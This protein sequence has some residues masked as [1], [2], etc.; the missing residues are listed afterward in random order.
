MVPW[1]KRL[2]YSLV[3]WVV[4]SCV[5]GVLVSIWESAHFPSNRGVSS[6]SYFFDFCLLFLISALAIGSWGWLLGMPFVLLVRN[7]GGW[8]FWIY[9]AIGSSI[10][11]G[12]FFGTLLYS[13]LTRSSSGS[14]TTEPAD[15]SAVYISTA[16]SS[17]T[18][19]IYL[20]LL[21]RAQLARK[22]N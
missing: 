17:L 20:S 5:L 6:V 1:W 18:T 8:R 16:V 13:F 15:Y 3:G 14:M 2:A 4:A 11:P 7:I 10:G 9:L 22:S 21:R 19:L 12:L